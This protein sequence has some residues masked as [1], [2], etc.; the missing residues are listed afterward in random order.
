MP[1]RE[2]LR[3]TDFFSEPL[4][5]VSV[6]GTIDTS[7]RS[8]AEE[9]GVAPENLVGRRLDALASAS[10][11]AIQEYLRACAASAEVIQGSLILRRRADTIALQARG[12]AYPVDAAPS[13]SQVLLRL[14]TQE[15][16]ARQEPKRDYSA[17][18]Q[19]IEDSLRRQSQI[20]EVTLASIGD[21]V[22]VTDVEGRATFI[23]SVAAGLIGW[24]ARE[25]QRRPL[26]EIFRIVNEHTG[27]P[28]E[29][30]VEKVL[31]TGAISGLANHTML[32]ARDGRAIPIDDSAAPIR[33]PDGKLFGVVLIFRD[34]T[35]QR[36]AHQA[37]AR[38]A[39]IVES[40]DD[41]IVSKT[42]DGQ[43]TSWNPGA[44]RIFGYTPE[45]AIGRPITLIV[46]PELYA[47]EAQVLARLRRGERVDHFETIRIRKDGHRIDVSLTVSPVR[48]E[49]GE[50]VGASKIARDITERKRAERELQQANA[51]K[52][53]FLAVLGHELRN[54][55][56]PMRNALEL[57]SRQ[58]SVE[59]ESRIAREIL[60]R[61]LQQMT[62]LVEDLLDV[63]RI[64]AGRV[65]LK[66]EL[67]ELGALLQGIASALRSNFEASGQ[68]LALEGASSALWVKGDRGRL[69]QVFS[70]ILDNARKYTPQG[71]K[72]AVKLQAEQRDAAITIRDSGIGIPPAMLEQIFELFTQV[73]RFHERSR[74]GLGIGLTLARRLLELQGGSIH[75][76]SAGEGRGSEFT[77][78]LPL[79]APP[80]PDGLSTEKL[81]SPKVSH[82]ILIADDNQDGALTLSMLLR[83]MGH[84]TRVVLDGLAAVEAAEAFRP[85][86]VVLDLDMPGLDGLQTARRIRERPWAGTV[87]LVALTG[88]GQERHRKLTDQA[89]FDRH[90]L[91]PVDA[92]AL[93]ELLA[94]LAPPPERQQ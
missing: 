83:M 50:I 81:E 66:E 6:D 49:Q 76:Y 17:Q 54:P 41:A 70:N 79:Q 34:I 82:R 60:D 18:W 47:E 19:D 1:I 14:V 43:I 36:R 92:E 88:L 38:L 7:N 56:A 87:T 52:D 27:R 24:P 61:Q 28:V 45:E 48:D 8:F 9:L 16:P 64:T 4:A 3:K 40:S 23:N 20:L 90:W 86:V 85:N 75:G 46:P 68:T 57:L 62:R 69:I 51:R 42:L 15:E 74:G 55:L 12:V 84:E 44:V 53:E 13:A 77:I 31:Q 21:A 63:S 91:K 67:I 94:G 30:P 2:L 39:A 25:A 22:I 80:A 89:G 37:L 78:R 10:A 26:N 59:S 73:D 33:L 32:L 93:R 71:G 29:N 35:T 65:V 58:K 11:S 5:L 72:I